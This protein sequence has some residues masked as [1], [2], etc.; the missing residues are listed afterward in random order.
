MKQKI[1]NKTPLSN[2]YYIGVS[3]KYYQYKT[4]YGFKNAVKKVKKKL[5]ESEK[6]S[7][8]EEYLYYP[9]DDDDNPDRGFEYLDL[10][11]DCADEIC[12]FCDKSNKKLDFK[13]WDLDCNQADE[14]PLSCHCCGVDLV[15]YIVNSDIPE[16]LCDIQTIGDVKRLNKWWKKQYENEE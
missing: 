5:F 13:Y 10:C 15:S 9:G 8:L 3:N 1:T 2:P 7:C 11:E 12:K 4:E 14:H 6:Y 16:K